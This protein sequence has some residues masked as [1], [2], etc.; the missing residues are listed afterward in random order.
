MSR[1]AC[2]LALAAACQRGTSSS[3]GPTAQAYRD[4]VA[5]ICDAM[6]LS[7]ADQQ[8]PS[9]HAAMIA[10]WLGPHLKT[11]EAHDYLVRIQPL[12]GNAKADALDDEAK[13]VGLAGCALSAEWRK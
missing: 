7:G 6:T 3:G 10:M 5:S 2:L 4:D 13:R 12:V 9:A 1:L 11:S 8:P